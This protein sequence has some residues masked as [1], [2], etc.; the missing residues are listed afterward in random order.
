MA[1]RDQRPN[2]DVEMGVAIGPLALDAPHHR[3]RRVGVDH[4]RVEVVVAAR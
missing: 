4:D 2:R 3:A 1:T